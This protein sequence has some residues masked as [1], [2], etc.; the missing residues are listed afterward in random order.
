MAKDPVQTDRLMAQNPH[1]FGQL[2]R[3]HWRFINLMLQ[4][5]SLSKKEAAKKLGLKPETLYRWPKQVD[6]ALKLA[7]Q[8]AHIAARA[9][10]RQW[11]LE[12]LNVKVELLH[13]PDDAVRNRAASDIIEWELGKA[14]QATQISGPDN[15]PITIR[16]EYPDGDDDDDDDIHHAAD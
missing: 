7:L 14:T 3:N 13:S 16:F 9:M 12:A 15:G 11:L 8:D 6:E 10:R 5:P 1:I 4:D 2:N